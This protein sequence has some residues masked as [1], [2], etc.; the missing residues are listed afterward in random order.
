M[1]AKRHTALSPHW[2]AARHA[3]S[4]RPTD[5]STPEFEQA[6]PPHEDLAPGPAEP[7]ELAGHADIPVLERL[8]ASA[9]EGDRCALQELASL[10]QPSV[11]RFAYHLS[12]NREIAEE[13]CQETW[14]RVI[15][16]LPGFRAESSI[17][18]WL[19]AIARRVTA[20]L[21]ADQRRNSQRWISSAFNP[22][23][24]QS[25]TASIEIELELDRLP[26]RLREAL[27]LT[28]VVGLTYEETAI[29]AGVKVGTIRSR[30][31]RARSALQRNLRD[32]VMSHV[33]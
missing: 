29:L 19:L 33:V 13:A 27:I 31:F 16:A 7:A 30:V 6:A 32:Q 26:A 12:G 20:G 28:Q 18:T 21:L 4:P 3:R 9:R 22:P 2:A 23:P 17:T 5:A 24:S 14:A 1:L 11:W 8:A 25:S 15:R 10:L